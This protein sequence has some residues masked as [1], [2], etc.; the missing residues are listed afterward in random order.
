[1]SIVYTD[2][3]LYVYLNRSR[4]ISDE[5]DGL[6]FTVC[7][8]YLWEVALNVGIDVLF[9]HMYVGKGIR[10]KEGKVSGMKDYV[11]KD[12]T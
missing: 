3:I 2:S 1:V 8:Y 10:D 5:G 4:P 9:S 7:A 11:T 6:V 12:D